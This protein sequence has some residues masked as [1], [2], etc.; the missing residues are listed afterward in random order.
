[1]S[2]DKDSVYFDEGHNKWV[3]KAQDEKNAYRPIQNDKYTG[4][5]LFYAKEN[6][7]FDA[8]TPTDSI[9]GT[10]ISKKTIYVKQNVKLAGQL[11]ADYIKIDA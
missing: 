11:L 8:L 7:N 3:V 2:D 5:L 1:M 6:I 9:Q 4:N 10:F